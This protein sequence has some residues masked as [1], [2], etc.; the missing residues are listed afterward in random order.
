MTN[1]CARCDEPT[2]VAVKTDYGEKF[3]CSNC[4]FI[5]RDVRAYAGV[6]LWG[7]KTGSELEI[8]ASQESAAVIS[9]STRQG[10]AV[11]KV[12]AVHLPK[13][14]VG[15]RENSMRSAAVHERLSVYHHGLAE[16]VG[17]KIRE[18]LSRSSLPKLYFRPCV[19]GLTVTQFRGSILTVLEPHLRLQS[20]KVNFDKLLT[21]LSWSA[22]D[23]DKLRYVLALRMCVE[24]FTVKGKMIRILKSKDVLFAITS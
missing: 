15:R 21:A 4:N 20:D 18:C 23:L 17:T 11:G 16:D 19:G 24:P 1:V 12:E 9:R 3:V 6:T 14:L 5:A 7:H 22:K 10:V 8:H 13:E 2:V